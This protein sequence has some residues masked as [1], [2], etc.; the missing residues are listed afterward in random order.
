MTTSFLSSRAAPLQRTV[1]TDALDTAAQR[2]FNLPPNSDYFP[3]NSRFVY[4]VGNITAKFPSLSLEKALYQN[5]LLDGDDMSLFE[6]VNDDVS[7]MRLNESSR[8]TQ[9]LFKALCN[10]K[11]R[12]IARNMNWVL[13]NRFGDEV[14]HLDIA[15]DDLL[16]QCIAALERNQEPDK[17]G[18]GNANGAGT[19]VIIGHSR[20]AGDLSVD[21]IMPVAVMPYGQIIQAEQHSNA[22][23]RE[24]AD[25]ITSLDASSGNTDAY[26]ALNFVLYNNPAILQK[27]YQLCFQPRMDGPNSSGYKLTGVDVDTLASGDRIVAD[28]IFN[29][30]GINT[31]AV[32]Y[33]YSRVD[34][35]GEYPFLVEELAEYLPY[36][37]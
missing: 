17:K 31:G 11:N 19:V 14:Y 37:A 5:C 15:T 7:L 13:D 34:V 33:W 1:A 4:V 25:T 3:E 21:A 16:T 36:R 20:H 10:I 18:A 8:L 9:K 32:Q 12:Y 6:S 30:Q 22:K 27:S 29:Y 2:A 26:R 35:T 24:L 23:L 28:V